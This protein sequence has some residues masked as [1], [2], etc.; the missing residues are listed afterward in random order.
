M[1][2]FERNRGIL[3]LYGLYGLVYGSKKEYGSIE[4]P[5]GGHLGFVC[6]SKGWEHCKYWF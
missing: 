3:G 6:G 4:I 2:K 5:V 1:V